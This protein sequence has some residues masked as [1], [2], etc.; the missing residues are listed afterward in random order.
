MAAAIDRFG[1]PAAL[2]ALRAA[3]ETVRT[4]RREGRERSADVADIAN[5]AVSHLEAEA[6]P[7]IRA[8]FN[9]TGTILHTNL[10]RAILAETAIAAATMAMREA[11]AL[12][13][14]LGS[15]Q[16]GERDSLVRSLLC[17]LTGRKTQPSSTTT[18]PRCCWCSTRSASA[19]RR[20]SRA[21]N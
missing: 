16:R 2:A 12:E 21:A 20:S 3:I 1:R 7:N 6:A 18:P 11:V 17:E 14:D 19:A 10:G 4:A 5:K 9:F 8:V 13:F 15:G